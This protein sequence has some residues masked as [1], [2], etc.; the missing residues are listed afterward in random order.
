AIL[1][2]STA[3]EEVEELFDAQ[4]AESARVLHGL[5]IETVNNSDHNLNL[6]D[7]AEPGWL[8]RSDQEFTYQPKLSGHRYEHKIAFALFSE[9][10]KLLIRSISGDE[11]I[12]SS[13]F[14]S[15]EGFYDLTVG[16]HGW[17][18]FRVHDPANKMWLQVAERADVRGELVRN[19]A[20]TT[21]VPGLL[22]LPVFAFLAY[23]YIKFG[24]DPLNSL[25]QQIAL[26]DSNDLS[27]IEPNSQLP[28]ELSPLRDAFNSFMRQ[29]SQ[30]IMR[31]KRF[32]A[33]AAHELRTP[34]A[35]LKIH[36]QNALD[37]HSGEQRNAALE[38][39]VQGVDRATRVVEQLLTLAR[40]EPHQQ[41][42]ER[43]Q[44]DFKELV[45]NEV[46]ALAPLAI[47]KQQ[48]IGFTA[49]D[50]SVRVDGY[51]LALSI[52]VKNL[53]DNAI[54][55]TPEQGRVDVLLQVEKGKLILSV[56]DSGPGL[57]EDAQQR[58]FERFY[59]HETGSQTGAGLGL[60]IASRVTELHNGEIS[61]KNATP[62]GCV[63]QFSM[64]VLVRA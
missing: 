12:K 25:A 60:S 35:V 4:L 31:E 2:F 40:L 52:L 15:R 64:P 36:A 23:R 47:Q 9:D 57:S 27:A 53:L 38:K 56:T 18:V 8:V 33:D 14:V 5:L 11:L 61:L 7:L 16:K 10:G 50:E 43:C 29:L 45:R 59:R 6:N 28:T 46:A 3:H 1:S 22:M 26:R 63:A 39:L 41:A 44:L 55:Y 62:N 19:I 42:E 49:C 51:P 17:R 48:E 54:R 24:L 34:L 58:V 21:V 20:A 37:A 32:T 30:A 13:S